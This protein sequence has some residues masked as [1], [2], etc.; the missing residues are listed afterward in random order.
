MKFLKQAA[1]E[2]GATAGVKAP[3]TGE[4]L[5][6]RTLVTSLERGI[7]RRDAEIKELK[8]AVDNE[9]RVA[10][11]LRKTVEKSQQRIGELE[12]GI[13]DRMAKCREL[14]DALK[15]ERERADAAE[16]ALHR[17]DHPEDAAPAAAKTR[18]PIPTL[19]ALMDDDSYMR[20]TLVLD[21]D[22][23][24]EPLTSTTTLSK[25]LP[26]LDSELVAPE[27]IFPAGEEPGSGDGTEDHRAT[28][29]DAAEP[30]ELELVDPEPKPAP[31]V[32]KPSDF[33]RRLAIVLDEGTP[34]RHPI[35]KARM[36]IGRSRNADIQIAS[37]FISRVHAFISTD[38]D[39]TFVEDA[40]SK[41]GVRVNDALIEGRQAI[42][43]GDS[44]RLGRVEFKVVD[45]SL[46]EAN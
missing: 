19:E 23:E 39:G 7:E 8:Q 11:A 27:L 10:E 42:A 26:N 21:D 37:D 14:R 33:N 3:E 24:E 32:A 45:L 6:Q 1:D 18:E 22:A 20:E 38:E 46:D 30:I 41:N 4:S 40:G 28:T 34:I 43:H 29:A 17:R 9:Q 25:T 13:E 2:S 36:T 15:A 5:Q 44:M 16:E 35:Y 31:A 12:L